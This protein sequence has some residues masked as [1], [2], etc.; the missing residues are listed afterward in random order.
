MLMLTC[1]APASQSQI[2]IKS[3]FAG[4]FS[5]EQRS[6]AQIEGARDNGV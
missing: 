1:V 2:W 5:E 6:R 3:T 4:R